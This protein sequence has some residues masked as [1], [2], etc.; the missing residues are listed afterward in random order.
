VTVVLFQSLIKRIPG[1][2]TIQFVRFFYKEKESVNAKILK[3]GKLALQWYRAILFVTS[4]PICHNEAFLIDTWRTL[5]TT[6]FLF[7]GER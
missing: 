6:V 7:L 3:V 5:G 4:S 1:Y 2:L